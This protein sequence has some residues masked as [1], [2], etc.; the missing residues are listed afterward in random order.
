MANYAGVSDDDDKRS[1]GQFAGAAPSAGTAASQ[2]GRAPAASGQSGLPNLNNAGAPW[3]SASMPNLSNAGAPSWAQGGLP[4]LSNAG[5]PPWAQNSLPNL[6]NAGAAST[7]SARNTAAQASGPGQMARAQTNGQGSAPWAPQS[8]ALR[9]PQMGVVGGPAGPAG[10]MPGFV[11]TPAA[12]IP[13][14]MLAGQGPGPNWAHLAQGIGA[15]PAVAPQA[16]QMAAPQGIGMPH[17]G[18][19]MNPIAQRV[20]AMMAAR[21]QAMAQGPQGPMPMQRPPWMGR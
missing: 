4:N 11:G 18:G 21:R 6:S 15:G 5:A 13:P 7:A 2:Y 9:A 20:A 10:P 17:M 1:M 12:A 3:A 14:W 19:Q 16:P 8:E